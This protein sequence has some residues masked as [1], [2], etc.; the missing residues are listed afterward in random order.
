MRTE[1]ILPGTPERIRES[2]QTL[3]QRS[4]VHDFGMLMHDVVVLDTET[5]G[6]SSKDNELIEISAARMTVEG[7]IDRFDTFV[8]PSKLI[9]P[10][11]T[12]L[13][14]I[15][16]AQV[17]HAPE[18]E[19]AVAR[20]A[21]FAQGSPIVAHNA[22]FDRAFI[23]AVPGGRAVS[24]LWID[25]L[26]LSRIAMPRL[27]SH[28]LADMA[29]YFGVSAVSHR[30]CDDVDALLGMWPI[31]LTALTDLPDGLLAQLSDMHADVAWSY[32]PL[33]SYLAQLKPGGSFSLLNARQAVLDQ[34][35]AE[36]KGDVGDMESLRAPSHHEIEAAFSDHGVVSRMYDGYEARPEQ[37]AMAFEVSDA[38]ATGTHRVIEAGTGVGK[39]IAYLI[40]LIAA[41]KLNGIT[42]GVATKSNNL[43]DQLMYHE[44]PRLDREWDG[45][46][47]Y[48][49]LKGYDHYPCLRKVEQLRRR[50]AEIVTTKDPQD[51]LTAIA[52]IL[53]Y[54]CQSPEGD[55]DALGIRWKSVDR[56][57]LT[58]SA[59]ECARQL[60]PFYPNACLVHGARRRA[61]KADVVVTNHSLLFR[62][63]AAEGRILP[64]IRVWVVDEAHSI[65][66]EAR[67]Q[68][69]VAIAADDVRALFERLGNDRTGALKR[70]SSDLASS[71]AATLY[72]GLV[73]KA[74]SLSAR[75]Q[76]AMAGTFDAV[77]SFVQTAREDGMDSQGVW[78][79]AAVRERDDWMVVRQRGME[80]VDFLE[81]LDHVLLGAIEAIAADQPE[82]VIEVTDLERRLHDVLDGLKV[83]L[84]GSDER[85]V[86]SVSAPRRSGRGGEA[87]R[88]ELI[89][90][91]EAFHREWYPEARSIIFTS[92]TVAVSGSFDHFA[93]AV[94][95]DCLDDGSWRA[96]HLDSSYD[97]D[98]NMAV[99]VVSSMPDPRQRDAYLDALERLLVD[100]HLAMGGSVLTLFTNR[101]DMEELYERVHPVLAR[102]GL[103]L[104]CQTRQSS[105]RQLRDH[106]I[107][108]KDS[109]L[110]A[111]KAFW[112]GFD[113]SGETLRCVV[114]PKLP[115]ARPTDPLARE[116]DQREKGAWG[117]YV[118]PEAV[119]E[120]KQAAG[121]LI[122]SSSDTGVLV[123]ADTRLLSKGYGKKFLSSLPTGLYHRVDGS[124]VGDFLTAWSRSHRAGRSAS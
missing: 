81:Q 102:H 8:H 121:R 80:A 68:W 44:L 72:M 16:N 92:A 4:R 69:A 9:P 13:T 79:N 84:D 78:I 63:I 67:R 108:E 71:D 18:P 22:S 116:R 24:D 30:A 62:N 12:S 107:A 53:S 110:F 3:A 38:I 11:I 52:V 14:S 45:G 36:T 64:P 85:Y 82:A 51:T 93:H 75:A 57:S 94:G 111:L 33:F 123:L 124:R 55:L 98:S 95:L 109:S 120:L 32:R 43:A 50:G 119:I 97:F 77:H 56:G 113:A 39:S 1:M 40:P 61:A 34:D 31:I 37:V 20:L 103:E 65:E 122:R 41:A 106:F 27:A 54:V 99:V 17:L 91:G 60:C 66:A 49:A 117:R 101:R 25:S 96:V 48:C 35:T 104:A 26:A 89:D 47:S 7:S 115:F 83:V 21:A 58:T 23:E 87:F 100:T 112:E 118:L 86:Y 46:V 90:I 19:D 42:V 15:T 5:T 76:D 74:T 105:S 2:Y 114:I 70:L 10:E 6:L 73:A 59:R 29:D 28:K 88:A